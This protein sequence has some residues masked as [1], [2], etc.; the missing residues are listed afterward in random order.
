MLTELK[1]GDMTVRGLSVGGIY[2]ALHVPQFD[3]GLDVGL[4]PRTL[5]G[6][7]TLLLTHGHVDHVGSLGT[8]LGIRALQGQ[9]S[10]LRVIMP[11][12]IVDAV[13]H[14]LEATSALQH[15]PLTIEA[16]GLRAG[17][18]TPLGSDL[19]VRAHQAF[20]LVPCLAYEVFRRVRKLHPSW[21]GRP[22]NEIARAR[23]AGEDIFAVTERPELAY[24]TD[25][26]VSVLDHAPAL[27]A[28]KTLIIEATFLDGRKSMEAVHAGCHIHLDELIARAEQF[29]NEH[30]V[31]MHFSQMYRPDEVNGI[32]DARLPPALRQRTH[33][34]VPADNANWP[35]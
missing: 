8:L 31:L 35:G 10:P 20:H 14:S 3:L 9:R 1:L 15:W 19:F 11:A 17:E 30:L 32:L 2:T 16:V 24:A 23:E 29:R 25:T 21:V 26:L 27:F 22:G 6:V 12:E 13:Q 34:L 4:A 33:A 7:R 28:A 18:E 5:A